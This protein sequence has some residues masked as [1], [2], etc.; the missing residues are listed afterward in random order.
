MGYSDYKGGPEALS[1][2]LGVAIPAIAGAAKPRALPKRWPEP[3]V[4]KAYQSGWQYAPKAVTD[5]TR[6][7]WRMTDDLRDRFGIGYDLVGKRIVI[8]V[9]ASETEYS[10]AKLYLPPPMRIDGVPSVKCYFLTGDDDSGGADTSI[11]FGMLQAVRAAEAGATDVWWT[12]G[13]GDALCLWGR[14][15]AAVSC[16]TGAGSRLGPA[17]FD[18]LRQAGVKRI[19]LATDNDAPGRL[20]SNRLEQA[21]RAAGLC[22]VVVEASLYQGEKDVSD[23]STADEEALDRLVSAYQPL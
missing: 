23:L 20:Y 6:K 14:G 13:E 22:S 15:V 10:C 9:R 4:I 16:L 1:A 21:A 18:R 7:V 19:V 2:M 3:Y 12:E 11:P 17:W 8:P 5:W